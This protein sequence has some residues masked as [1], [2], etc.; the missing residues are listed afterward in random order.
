MRLRR[1]TI[2]LLRY[3]TVLCEEADLGHVEAT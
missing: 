2:P 1:E 3:G